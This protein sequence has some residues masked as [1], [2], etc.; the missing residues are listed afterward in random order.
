MLDDMEFIWAAQYGGKCKVKGNYMFWQ[1]ADDARIGGIDG[2]VDHDIWYIDPDKV[3][4]TYAK[5]RKNAVSI[6]ECKVK[7]D[8]D[9]Y[10][11]I[12][13]R[14][15]P[16]VQITYEGK[17]L[18]KGSHYE[19]SFVC[20]TTEGTGYAIIRGIDSYKDW[21]ALPFTIE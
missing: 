8:K 19:I 9:S 7:F 13:H 17:K 18:R 14:A 5:G 11:L 16:G 2:A 6:S 12:N 1:C 15:R 4:A 20:N 10:K 21:I 3:Y